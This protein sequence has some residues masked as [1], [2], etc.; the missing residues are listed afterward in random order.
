ML[1]KHIVQFFKK[2]RENVAEFRH[3][4]MMQWAVPLPLNKLVFHHWHHMSD[5]VTKEKC[6]LDHMISSN[7]FDGDIFK[8]LMKKKSFI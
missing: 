2:V 3:I 8:I 5:E 1:D 6:I 4:P 7:N